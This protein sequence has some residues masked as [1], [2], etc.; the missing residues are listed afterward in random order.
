MTSAKLQQQQPVSQQQLQQEAGSVQQPAGIQV[1]QEVTKEGQK[2][3][4]IDTKARIK[5]AILNA[6]LRKKQLGNCSSSFKQSLLFHELHTKRQS[7][8]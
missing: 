8:S 5:A 7:H 6:G 4:E 2:T 1:Q 3:E